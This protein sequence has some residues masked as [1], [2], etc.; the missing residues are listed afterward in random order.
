MRDY[1]SIIDRL[2]ERFENRAID[3]D[4]YAA[5]FLMTNLRQLIES[6]R[7][8][9]SYPTIYFYACWALHFEL[10]RNI[11]SQEILSNIIASFP[12]S[13]DVGPS[14]ID[15]LNTNLRAEE[16]RNEIRH[17]STS[18]GFRNILDLN[19]TWNSMYGVILNL[20]TDKPLTPPEKVKAG[21][22]L[23]LTQN[24]NQLISVDSSIRL[25]LSGDRGQQAE[26]NIAIVPD[27]QAFS[28]ANLQD[29]TV[30][31]GGVFTRS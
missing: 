22:N 11:T 16:L 17:L 28:M 14:F 23:K 13:S 24:Q 29:L 7:I 8:I 27:G 21:F 20:V 25:W 18:Y 10:D 12:D 30:I 26:W 2:F 1:S 5:C 9:N 31:N 6:N 3:F 15:L 19:Q 4:D